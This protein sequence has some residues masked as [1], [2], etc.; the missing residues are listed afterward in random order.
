[1]ALVRVYQGIDNDVWSLTFVNDPSYLS[2]GDKKAMRQFGEP[3]IAL[4]G[5]FLSETENE[6]TLP[7]KTA[8]LRSDFPFTQTFDSRD[9]T[10]SENTLTKVVG[11]RDAIITRITDAIEALREEADTFT[12]EHTYNI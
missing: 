12:G 1:M 2:E 5:T 6:F 8:K 3:E 7:A 9:E 4:G 10:F 11:Y